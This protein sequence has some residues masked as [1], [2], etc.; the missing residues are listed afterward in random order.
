MLVALQY[1]WHII[2]D[3]P[4]TQSHVLSAIPFLLP[5][6]FAPLWHILNAITMTMPEKVTNRYISLRGSGRFGFGM[7]ISPFSAMLQ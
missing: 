4:V 6:T 7:S 5:V 1:C 2:G 3:G